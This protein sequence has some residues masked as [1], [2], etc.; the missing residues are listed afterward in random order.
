M[1]NQ[2]INNITELITTGE[3][4]TL[5]FKSS[6]DRQAIET[7]SAFAN[8]KGGTVLVGV[9]NRGKIVGTEV[10]PETAQ[11]WINQVK[12]ATAP[13]II[14]DVD[15]LVQTGKQIAKLTVAEYPIKP[16]SC[17][18]K[19]FKRVQNANHR[20][21]LT[22]IS[23]LYLQTF[24]T[25]WDHY[26]DARH[27]LE[28][29]SLDKVNSF[30]DDA[31]KIRPYPMDD[32]P[33]TVLKKYEL[34]KGEKISNGCFLLFA[35]G[36]CFASSLQAGR[37]ASET[38]IKDS[39]S[40]SI[41][42]FTEVEQVLGF[43]QKHMNRAYVITGKSQR[44]EKWDYPLDGLR[45]IVTNMVVH[46]DY[47]DPSDSIIKIFDEHI[48]FF[49]PGK[50]LPGLN[51]QRLVRGDYSSKIR[52][53]QIAGIFKEA[54]K[55]EKYG[56]GIKRIIDAFVAHGLPIPEFE[57]FQHGF[58]VTIYKG[59]TPQ[60]TPQDTPQATPQVWKLLRVCGEASSREN[61]QQSLGI[62]D[63]KYFRQMYLAPAINAG[64]LELTIP[65]APNSPHQ[66]YR[67][68]V[69][70]KQLIEETEREQ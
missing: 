40:L 17:R 31:N 25:S 39:L 1:K 3:S 5:E 53:K 57:E 13:A 55:I 20:L 42:L 14:P 28:D 36:D 60:A 35:A 27:G 65:D 23:N 68:T 50:L 2:D 46:R 47:T 51:A 4:D 10:G 43:I 63:K 69:L 9:D 11:Q 29:I 59:A 7:L 45:E 52:N 56:S 54:G 15:F 67:L 48:Q 32:S 34:V 16:V 19:Y 18:G 44:E 24:N 6:F 49:N 70:G 41:D 38:I 66:R 58:R 21:S 22:E 61:L 12:S 64:L 33:L 37:F 30:I 62:K 8:T 26:A